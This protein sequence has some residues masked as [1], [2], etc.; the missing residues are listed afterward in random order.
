MLEDVVK[1][2]EAND[3]HPYIGK[4]FKWSDARDAYAALAAGS[5]VGKI[6]I[7]I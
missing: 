3:I 7:Q 6:V 4:V 5:T 2:F 1:A